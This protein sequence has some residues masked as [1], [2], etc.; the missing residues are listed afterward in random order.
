M[1]R[2][3]RSLPS[4]QVFSKGTIPN[5][6]AEHPYLGPKTHQCGARHPLPSDPCLL[7]QMHMLSYY[8]APKTFFLQVGIGKSR[9]H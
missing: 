7:K 9:F 4:V 1:A 6:A 8:Y 3:K 2:V 5:M